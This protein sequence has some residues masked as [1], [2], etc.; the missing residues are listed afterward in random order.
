MEIPWIAGPTLHQEVL[1]FCV[2]LQRRRRK[3]PDFRRSA[4]LDK[5]RNIN[6]KVMPPL[7]LPQRA[8][9]NIQEL[10]IWQEKKSTE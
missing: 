9:D 3:A 10:S 6:L 5:T 2:R 1:Q 4:G 7:E 8:E